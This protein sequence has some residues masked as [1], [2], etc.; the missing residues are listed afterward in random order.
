VA[1][2]TSQIAT[3]ICCVAL[4]APLKKTRTIEPTHFLAAEALKLEYRLHDLVNAAYGLTSEEVRLMW[5]TTPP[6]MP[7]PRRVG[8]NRDSEREPPMLHPI[9][10]G[11]RN[12]MHLDFDPGH[13]LLLL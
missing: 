8:W 11:S 6:W 7:I 2:A 1:S 5:D 10:E 13:C 3:A 9:Q 4:S 12:C